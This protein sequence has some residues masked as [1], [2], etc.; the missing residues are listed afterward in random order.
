[1]VGGVGYA[2]G[3]RG[4]ERAAQEA[5][6]EQRLASLESAQAPAPAQAA[7]AGAGDTDA[8]IAQLKELAKL[9]EAGVLTEVELER[10]KQKILGG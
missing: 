6:Q 9:R 2:A 10:E 4:A 3:R 5:G 8:K 1:M 7:P